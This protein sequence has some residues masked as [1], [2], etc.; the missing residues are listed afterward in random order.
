M[1]QEIN[2][3]DN[4]KIRNAAKLKSR[5]YRN[6]EQAFLAEGR[7]I[8]EEALKHPENILRIFVDH[9]LIEDY[10]EW[11]EKY[12]CLEWYSVDKK[13]I[14]YISDTKTPQGIIAVMRKPCWSLADFI[15]R[16][17]FL[18][19]L[20]H[21]ADPGNMGT[22]IRSGWALGVAGIMLSRECV[23]PY[24]PKVV[25]AT[26]GGILHIPLFNNISF[27]DL[28]VLKDAGFKLLCS[29]VDAASTCYDMDFTGKTVAFI[30]SESHGVSAQI[31]NYCDNCFKIPTNPQVDSLNA[32][33]AC[34][35]IIN[36]AWKQNMDSFLSE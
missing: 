2:S 16:P 31:K 10:R 29:S 9:S 28:Q 24:S 11:S 32:A 34:A 18:L 14:D 23:D 5:K 27:Q 35:I 4:Q 26:M 15:S 17:S 22:I 12:N 36:E 3:I 25:R 19:F 6:S 20:D 30:G 1:L 7:K 8:L 33:V 13:S 21:I